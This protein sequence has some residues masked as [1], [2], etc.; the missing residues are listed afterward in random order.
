LTPQFDIAF[1]EDWSSFLKNPYVI[2]KASIVEE[3]IDDDS[4]PLVKLKS[5]KQAELT[6]ELVSLASQPEV[7]NT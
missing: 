4:E 7:V 3:M 5:K 6:S 1:D 2:G